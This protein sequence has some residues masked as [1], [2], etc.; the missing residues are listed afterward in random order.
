M[1]NKY[2]NLKAQKQD[3]LFRRLRAENNLEAL[4]KFKAQPVKYTPTDIKRL[5]TGIG[6]R[7]GKGSGKFAKVGDRASRLA[8][9]VKVSKFG[10]GVSKAG[11]ALV[12][13]GKTVAKAAPIIGP[14]SVLAQHY[15]KPAIH[16]EPG[17]DEVIR[18]QSFDYK[19]AMMEIKPAMVALEAAITAATILLGMTGLAGVIVGIIVAVLEISTYAAEAIIEENSGVD[20]SNPINYIELAERAYA[21]EKY[22]QWKADVLAGR[23]SKYSMQVQQWYH[24]MDSF[25]NEAFDE[26][27]EKVNSGELTQEELDILEELSFATPGEALDIALSLDDETFEKLAP[28]IQT[29]FHFQSQ[30][31]E[32]NPDNYKFTDAEFEQV[33]KELKGQ[34][35]PVNY[36]PTQQALMEAQN[37]EIIN[38]LK[39]Y[40]AGEIT[41]DQLSNGAQ[42]VVKE[43]MQSKNKT[44]TVKP[45][46][47]RIGSYE[48]Y[49]DQAEADI[50]N[51]WLRGDME[52]LENATDAQKEKFRN[53]GITTESQTIQQASSTDAMYMAKQWEQI[54]VDYEEMGGDRFEKKTGRD[55]SYLEEEAE[56]FLDYLDERKAANDEKLNEVEKKLEMEGYKFPAD[57]DQ[58]DIMMV[59]SKMD[60]MMKT[61]GTAYGDYDYNWDEL[62]NNLTDLD[63]L[64]DVRMRD[65]QE[66]NRQQEMFTADYERAGK[67]AFGGGT[68]Y[69]VEYTRAGKAALAGGNPTGAQLSRKRARFS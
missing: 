54:S 45:G 6:G 68:D 19:K 52:P 44:N 32:H 65:F 28:L 22:E 56:M 2:R 48:V 37:A 40:H 34:A 13:A 27:K 15:D 5:R 20:W 1:Y 51:A 35:G 10:Q 47:V 25:D 26:L 42:E 41:F 39:Q 36:S 8:R 9:Q 23:D 14:V 64:W 55:Y 21:R 46:M 43:H 30:M 16:V 50:Y 67:A 11:S 24:L 62:F 29:Q 33:I 18:G 49:L 12:K 66:Y 3:R 61:Q 60:K 59:M 53:I 57:M 38:E 17:F 63:D 69:N 4:E 7:V 31:V 58:A